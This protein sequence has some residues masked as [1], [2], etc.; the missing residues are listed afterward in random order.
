MSGIFLPPK[1]MTTSPSLSSSVFPH[2][3]HRLSAKLNLPVIS[4][5]F[6]QQTFNIY[7]YIYTHSLSHIH[8]SAV[9]QKDQ[10]QSSPVSLSRTHTHTHSDSVYDCKNNTMSR[11]GNVHTHTGHCSH[12]HTE[13]QSHGQNFEQKMHVKV[14]THS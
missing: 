4:H 7:R 1:P 3:H 6:T 9:L 11:Q 8:T 10:A 5:A 14:R 12:S 2:P 13:I